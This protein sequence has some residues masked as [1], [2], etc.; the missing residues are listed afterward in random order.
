M[1]TKY[2]LLRVRTVLESSEEANCLNE[3]IVRLRVVMAPSISL[4]RED[5]IMMRQARLR[6]SVHSPALDN[7][8]E[9]NFVRQLDI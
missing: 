3:S 1:S 4:F 2:L 6:R 8:L 5:N 9:L 7:R